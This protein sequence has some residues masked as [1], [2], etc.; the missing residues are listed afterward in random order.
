M[1]SAAIALMFLGSAAKAD[2]FQ[3]EYINP[4]DPSQGKRQS[5]TLAPGG[6]GV[7]PGQGVSLSTLNLSMAYLI[8]ADLRNANTVE[9]NFTAADLS[10]ADLTG[11]GPELTR[12]TNAN[13][14]GANLTNANFPLS[15]WSGANLSGAVVRSTN[16]AAATQRGFTMAQLYSTAS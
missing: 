9:T 15:S 16:F 11:A 7:M 10:G 14:S 12:F 8:G 4:A 3:W 6:A 1:L 2:I 13:L 5:A